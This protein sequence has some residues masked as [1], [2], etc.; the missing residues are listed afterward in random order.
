[1][2]HKRTFCK[3]VD[4]SQCC[5]S[6]NNSGRA[7]AVMRVQLSEY[8]QQN[9]VGRWAERETRM[10]PLKML[11]Y[12]VQQSLLFQQD[13]LSNNTY[14]TTTTGPAAGRVAR[15]HN[16][17]VSRKQINIVANRH[18]PIMWM[19]GSIMA[20]RGNVNGIMVHWQGYKLPKRKLRKKTNSEE[21]AEQI[22]RVTTGNCFDRWVTLKTFLL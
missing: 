13:R 20:N 5:T 15:Q 8:A 21:V 2:R 17:H 6:S 19:H 22:P 16:N 4:P 9:L 10:R 14:T 3:T 11:I 1:V 7:V 12:A 18:I